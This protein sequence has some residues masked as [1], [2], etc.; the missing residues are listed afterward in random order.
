MKKSEKDFLE[1]NIMADPIINSA[2][3]QVQPLPT[4]APAPVKKPNAFGR[5]FGGILGGAASIMLPG[6]GGILGN[7]LG[8]G[9]NMADMQAMMNQQMQQSMQLLSVQNRVQSQT[10][11]FS[12]MSNLLKAKHD[13]EMSAVNNFKS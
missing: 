10:Q 11:E 8:G 2:P 13:S 12:T 4:Y 9:N 3:A 7:V 1:E 6:V 5:I